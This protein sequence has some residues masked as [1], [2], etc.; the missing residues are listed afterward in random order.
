MDMRNQQ[1]ADMLYE[2]EATGVT[3]PPLTEQDG[4]LTI[5]DAYAIQLAN[6]RRVC[7][8][9]H[10]ITGKKIGITS[11]AMQEQ[12]GV[13]EPD[14]GHLFASMECP[15]GVIKTDRLLQPRIEA[16]VAFILK[17]DLTG[18]AVRAE[19]VRAATDYVV[20]AFEICDSRVADWHIKLIDTVADNASSG[21]YVL[22]T[23]R[24]ALADIDLPAAHMVLRKNGVKVAEGEGSAVIGDPANAV[25]WLANRLWGY[26]VTLNA[27]E[28]VLSGSFAAMV[29][30]ARGDEFEADFGSLGAVS[31]RFV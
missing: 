29:D 17:D 24:R 10:R 12:L 16:E 25:A 28:V 27:G 2:A 3:V 8:E 5:D 15:D 26:G 23:P 9:G 14:Y 19:D 13:N 4:S 21:R 6:V 20:A 18:G 1:F 22:G 11:F 7:A 30:A 31:A